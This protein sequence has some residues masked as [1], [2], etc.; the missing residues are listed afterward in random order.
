M[1]QEWL[2]ESSDA[3]LGGG[4]RR[5]RRLAA[6]LALTAAAP[7]AAMLFFAWR[8]A[9]DDWLDWGLEKLGCGLLL[10]CV[11]QVINDLHVYTVRSLRD[12]C[13]SPCC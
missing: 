1:A 7:G 2:G 4:Q 5:R 6:A 8:S 10:C 9:E 3:Q 11:V 12:L 13:C